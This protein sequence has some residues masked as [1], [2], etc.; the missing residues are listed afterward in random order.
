MNNQFNRRYL[1]IQTIGSDDDN[2]LF[3]VILKYFLLK[4]DVYRVG[5]DFSN[6]LCGLT[7][8]LLEKSN[9]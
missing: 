2:P 9:K 8:N 7:K 3:H 5:F 4:I 1:S 6:P